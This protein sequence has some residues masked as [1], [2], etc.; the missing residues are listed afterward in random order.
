MIGT[1]DFLENIYGAK[2]P[3]EVWCG[4]EPRGS[5]LVLIRYSFSLS[6]NSVTLFKELWPVQRETPKCYVIH[7]GG[8]AERWILKDP[9]GKRFAY[10]SDE[11]A[12]NSLRIRT[13][14]RVQH[15]RNAL[16]AALRA[17][18]FLENFK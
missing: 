18:E 4:L 13:R 16:D 5:E 8:P 11:D 1:F 12:M 3:I 6:D 10:L 9:K 17:Q 7:W 15:A 2:D 14:R